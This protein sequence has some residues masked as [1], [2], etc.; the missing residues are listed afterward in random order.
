MLKKTM[1]YVDYDGNERT[2][3]FYFNMTKTEC[4]R[5]QLG[6]AGGLENMLRKIIAEQDTTKIMPIFEDIIRGAYGEKSLDGKRFIKNSELTE[7]FVQTEAYSNLIMELLTDADAASAFIR[8]IVPPDL[9][10]A[11]DK[12]ATDSAATAV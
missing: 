1:T 8:G 6:T 9:G 10:E 5:L 3:D 4:V 7:A 11:M 2:E 12:A